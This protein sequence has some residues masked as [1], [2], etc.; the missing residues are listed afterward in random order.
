MT[1]ILLPLLICLA[2]TAVVTLDTVRT[3]FIARGMKIQAA[4]LGLVEVTV[5]LFA[6]SQVMQNLSNPTC[7]IGYA[8]GFT[9]G[10]YLGIRIEERLA[11]GTQVVRVLTRRDAAELVTALRA[12]GHG[13]TSVE[14]QG[15][16]GGVHVLFTIVARKR[17]PQVVQM[18][19]RF[20][21][22]TL[23]LIEDVRTARGGFRQWQAP[24]QS[25][26]IASE[27]GR[28]ARKQAA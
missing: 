6:I 20:D 10:T 15:A 3:I 26:R 8:L 1:M 11:L 22:A 28:Q 18:I 14:G 21:P 19:E 16:T 27:A 2:E 9:L 17:L 23:Y 24:A 5:W 12:A 13:V 7:F 25:A 4:A